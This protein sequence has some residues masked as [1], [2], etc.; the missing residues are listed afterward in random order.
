LLWVELL[1]IYFGAKS[2][3]GLAQEGGD[4]GKYWGNFME[5]G[6]DLRIKELLW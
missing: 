1:V 5:Q 6:N 4:G 2:S 3:S